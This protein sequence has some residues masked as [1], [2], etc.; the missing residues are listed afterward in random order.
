MTVRL[1]IDRLVVE[2]LGLSGADAPRLRAA[3]EAELSARLAADESA[4]WSGRAV[5]ALPPGEVA[6]APGA[7]AETIGRQVAAALHAGLRT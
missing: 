7:G 3:L 2:G 5:P 4:R 1:H 6:L